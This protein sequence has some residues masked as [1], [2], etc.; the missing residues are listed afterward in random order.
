MCVCVCVCVRA[1]VRVFDSVGHSPNAAGS[2]P[3]RLRD[4][5]TLSQC[6]WESVGHP[7][8]AAGGVSETLPMRLRVSDTLS[9]RLGE[10]Q[11]ICTNVVRAVTFKTPA[12]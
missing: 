10:C 7:P 2:L 9:M 6:G 4:C 1:C 8:N 5:W 11:T 12:H 3:M